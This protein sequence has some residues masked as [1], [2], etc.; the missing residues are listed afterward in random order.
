MRFLSRINKYKILRDADFL[1][2][3]EHM[4]TVSLHRAVG[5][6]GRYDDV[7]QQFD[8]GTVATS[9]IENVRA[10]KETVTA[11]TILRLDFGDIK[12]GDVI[13][14]FQRN[15]DLKGKESLCIIHQSK[16]YYPLLFAPD[17][18]ELMDSLIGT[19]PMFQS[20][21]CSRNRRRGS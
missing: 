19:E 11:A 4:V 18:E 12:T 21:L 5:N 16:R 20:L 1:L 8:G 15:L 17:K 3:S 13:F 7:Y 10:L 2:L 9:V 14:R 6:S